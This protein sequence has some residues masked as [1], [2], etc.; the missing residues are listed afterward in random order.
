LTLLGASPDLAAIPHG[1]LAALARLALKWRG[2]GF[3]VGLTFCGFALLIYGAVIFRSGF[4][5][6]LL[7]LL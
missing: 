2:V 3:Q 1:E 7:G 4:F 6:R 5:P